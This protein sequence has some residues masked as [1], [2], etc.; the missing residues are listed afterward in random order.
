ML[1]WLGVCCKMAAAGLSSVVLTTCGKATAS[2]PRP[3]CSAVCAAASLG[4]PSGSVAR[5]LDDIIEPLRKLGREALWRGKTPPW[6]RIM[7]LTIATRLDCSAGRSIGRLPV[8]SRNPITPRAKRS[9]EAWPSPLHRPRARYRPACLPPVHRRSCSC[10][11]R[12]GPVRNRESS[13]RPDVA[14]KRFA[15]LRSR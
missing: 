5:R 3:S 14:I 15:G 13:P 6:A 10:R 1:P 8:T 9:L 2:P 4:R 12:L 7:A 11:C